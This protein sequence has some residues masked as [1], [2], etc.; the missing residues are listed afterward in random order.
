M[1]NSKQ[2]RK[3]A[4][5]AVTR[6]QHI[7]SQRSRAR[8]AIKSVRKAIAAGD[9][10]AAAEIFKQAQAVIDSSAD[11]NVLHKNAAARHKS[12]LSAAIKLMA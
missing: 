12:R 9:K 8:T 11:K 6:N 3:R 7:S 10:A 5:Q 4:R 1:A 2:A